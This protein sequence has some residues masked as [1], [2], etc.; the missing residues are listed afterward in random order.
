MNSKEYAP[1]DIFVKNRRFDLIYKILYLQNKDKS[2]E[3]AKF[4]ENLY[5]KHI[6]AFNG[7]FEKEPRKISPED[8]VNSFT[9]LYDSIAS[10]GF[11]MNEGTILIKDNLELI[12]GAHRLSVCLHLRKK[13]HCAIETCHKAKSHWHYDW[14]FFQERE[15]DE[16]TTNLGV[17]EYVKYNRNAYIV[18]IYPVVD[19]MHDSA[20]EQILEKYGFVYFKKCIPVTY[21]GLINLKRIKYGKER[22]AGT[23]END[24]KGLKN[25]AEKSN[26]SNN[27][28]VYVFVC[29]SLDNVIKAKAEIREHLALGN[30]SVHINDCQ[31]EAV[32]LAQTYFNDNSIFMINNRPYNTRSEQ[33]DYYVDEL[34]NYTKSTGQDLSRFCA[35][36]STPLGVFGIRQVRDFDFLHISE[37][38]VLPDN[39]ELSSHDSE[40]S[41][42]PADKSDMILDPRYHFYYR[43]V[44]FITLDVLASMKHQRG[45]NPKDLHDC[46]MISQFQSNKQM[47]KRQRQFSLHKV[48]KTLVNLIYRK[49]KYGDRRTVVLFNFVKFNYTK[50]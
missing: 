39:R 42:Y 10:R 23:A 38:F 34:K 46:Q 4:Y 29:D 2:P 41:Y 43:G 37:F 20:V 18:N 33:I 28:R 44:K 16:I 19:S 22:W 11:N 12:N 31:G 1:E 5:L 47:V 15:M 32:E 35:S 3:I 25:H 8:F 48:R 49:T 27:L 45:E 6:F 13:V 21:N 26:G 36:G 50:K 24:F 17:L 30:F 14:H 7:Y 40:L 9:K